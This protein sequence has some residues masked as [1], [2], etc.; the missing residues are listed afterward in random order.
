M[1]CFV[2]MKVQ[3]PLIIASLTSLLAIATLTFPPLPASREDHSMAFSLSDVFRPFA[4]MFGL[5]ICCILTAQEPDKPKEL[6]A[7]FQGHQE[8][9]YSVALS[10]D[11]KQML[12][13]SFD[14]TIK[15]WDLASGKEIRTFGGEKGHKNLVLGVIFAPDG[16]TFASASADNTARIWDVPLLKPLRETPLTEAGTAMAISP[17]GK[18]AAAGAKDGSIKVWNLA[19]GKDL[20][21]LKGHVGPATSVAYSPGNAQ[22]LAS[23]GV[24]G[25]LRFWNLADGKPIAVIG[26]HP[27]SA[28]A[29]QFAANGNAAYSASLDGMVKMWQLPPAASRPIPHPDTVRAVSF[30]SD[31]VAFVT[32]CL[33]KNVRVHNGDGT[34]V[35]RT[36]PAPNPLVSAAISSSAANG[37]T[38]AGTSTGQLLVW[39]GDGKP[40]FQGPAHAGELTGVAFHP[41][42][43][44]LVT[45]GADGNLIIWSLPIAPTKSIVQ[46]GDTKA[47]SI[48]VDGKRVL[49]VNADNQVRAWATANLQVEKAFPVAATVLAQ[50][51][52]GNS[53]A[54][55]GA[56]NIIRVQ[57]RDG[58]GMP[59]QLPNQGG[60]VSLAFHPNGAQI[61]AA[62]ADGSLKL[63]AL[64]FP[65]K[66]AKPLWEAKIA[67]VRFVTFEPKGNQFF[68]IGTDKLMHVADAKTGKDQKAP[69]AHDAALTDLTLSAD[70]A[71]AVTAGEDKAVKVWTLADG[72]AVAT[73]PLPGIPQRVA[74]SPNGARLAV[75]YKAEKGIA[76]AVFDA[77]N[78]KRLQSFDEMPAVFALS[79]APDNRG[80][81]VAADKAVYMLDAAAANVIEV[82]KGGATG[83]TILP[84]GQAITCGKD[85]TVKQWDLAA[86][87]Q[88]K[89]IAT[90]PDAV[91]A[92]T[93]S[94]DAVQIAAAAGKQIKVWNAADG[95]EVIII[96]HPAEVISL[97]F[98]ADHTRLVTGATDNLARVWDLTTG[99]ELQS[100]GHGA[101]I[102]GVAFNPAK[103]QNVVTASADKTAAVHTIAVA[104]A[105]AASTMPIRAL[106]FNAGTGHL[107]TAGDDKTVKVWNATAPAPERTFAGAGDAVLSVAVARNNTLVAASGADKTIRLYNFADGALIGAFS[108]PATVRSLSFHAS[109]AELL[110]SGDDKAATLWNVGF[111]AGNPP[112]PEFGKPIQAFAHPAGVPGAALSGDGSILVTAGEDKLARTW[113]VAAEGPTKNF[114]HPNLVDAAAYN[115]KGDLLATSCH[116]GNVR[117]WDI[118]KATQ[119]R[120]MVHTAPNNMTQQPPAVYCVAW[121]PDGTQI[122]SGGL[123]KVIKIWNAADGKLVREIKGYDE[124]MALFPPGAVYLAFAG[125]PS[126]A[127]L[128]GPLL[129][130]ATAPKGHR[131]GVFSVAFTPDGKQVVSGSS[132]RSIKLWNVASGALVREF[133]N[134][135]LPVAPMQ[136]PVSHPGWVY[137]LRFMPDGK[138]VSVG[139]APR[140]RGYIAV[141]NPADGKLISGVELA[142]GPFYGVAVTAEGNFAVA[143]GP[144]GRQIPQADAVLLKLPK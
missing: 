92:V 72:K 94:R 45:V 100:F 67:G 124:K 58:T 41:A 133:V 89:T 141:W 17:D 97:A 6:I 138:L 129:I 54:T 127:W 83:L 55:A 61:L 76:V 110:S 34:Q 113:K 73:I 134:P 79:F 14:K 108:A 3:V 52:D 125:T 116:D 9:V 38:A 44:Q 27:G 8:T 91:N 35:L 85:K 36:L 40:V 64:P 123:D 128:P 107:L 50:S 16:Q 29:V 101:A 32:A 115:P 39:S 130:G 65:A 143:C 56:D 111:T 70:G 126:L 22:T 71:R 114:Q 96:A 131:D 51:A 24:D 121:S 48:S 18:T 59:S 23:V 98:N 49:T 122:V 43:N 37:F 62:H 102:H 42:G 82:H 68:A 120:A 66:D 25:T 106:A 80:L 118:A 103:P 21:T 69:A 30:T 104:R 47:A 112:P 109:N 20:F 137:Y 77:A 33:D 84:N 144:R 13:A 87:K 28:T 60:V 2:L 46:P 139:G 26:A 99:K 15:L 7:T 10:S 5:L 1:L 117:I 11:S 63:W 140:N 57:R 74:L 135:K 93:L 75:A 78:G 19:D 4:V 95:K 31:G 136:P 142:L 132:D 86:G 12:T 105:L 88:I 81:I 90:L 119:L 53:I